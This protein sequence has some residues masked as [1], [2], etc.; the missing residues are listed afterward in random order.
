M[1]NACEDTEG[2]IPSYAI[3]ESVNYFSHYGNPCGDS[4]EN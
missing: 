2:N 3:D 1:I 4:S